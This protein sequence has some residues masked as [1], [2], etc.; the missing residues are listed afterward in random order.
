MFRRC[1]PFMALILSACATEPSSLSGGPFANFTPQQTLTRDAVGS[2]VRWGGTI[3]SVTPGKNETC[4]QVLGRPLDSSA[5]P[6]AD[7]RAEGRFI[8][9]AAGF[10]DPAVYASG[11]DLTVTGT[12]QVPQPGRIGEYEY[13]F[14]HI[15]AKAVYLW[16]KREPETNYPPPY[17]PSPFWHPW[18]FGPW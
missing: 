11:R 8:A 17:Y 16:P 12:V 15:A 14:P 6:E 4:F 5:R 2:L 13:R 3:L 7:D 18:G 9:C 1:R 10:Y